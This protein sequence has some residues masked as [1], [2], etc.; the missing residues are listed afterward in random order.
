M[1]RRNAGA[2]CRRGAALVVIVV[3]LKKNSVS[4]YNL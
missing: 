2:R 3:I 1:C 4:I